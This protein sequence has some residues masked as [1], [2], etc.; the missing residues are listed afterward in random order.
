M[1][2]DTFWRAIEPTNPKLPDFQTWL[3]KNGNKLSLQS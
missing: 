1:K 3:T 2:K